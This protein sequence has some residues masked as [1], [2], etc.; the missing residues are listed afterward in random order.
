LIRTQ[1]ETTVSEN[2]ALIVV[3]ATSAAS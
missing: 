3:V 2:N 1:W